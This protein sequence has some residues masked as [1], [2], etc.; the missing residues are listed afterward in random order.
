MKRVVVTGATGFIGENLTRRLVELG[1]LVSIIV[2][3]NSNLS[4]LSDI[5]GNLDIYRFDGDLEKLIK[6]FKDIKAE[7][8]FHLA[9]CFIA[10]HKSLD[11]ENLIDSNVKFGSFLLEAMRVSNVKNIINTGTAWQHYQNKDYNAV[12]LYAATKESFEKI[13]DYYVDAYEINAITLKIFDSYGE[14]DRRGK[15]INI[16]KEVSLLGREL[17]MSEGIQKIDLTHVEDIVE[18]Y[19]VAYNNLNNLNEKSHKRYA[20]CTERKVTLK[21]LIEIFQKE[22]GYEVKVNWGVRAQ[23]YREVISPWDRYEKLPNWKSKI[24]LEE[25]LKRIVK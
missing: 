10:E 25:G 23:R 6:Y 17:N 4:Y 18:G 15:L 19:I 22:T 2:R 1:F 5:S 13:I 16:L 24:S 21:E 14:N 12:C 9:S 8:V 3:E 11:V 7:A 20:I